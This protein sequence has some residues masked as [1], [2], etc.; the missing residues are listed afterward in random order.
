MSDSLLL[1]PMP[2]SLETGDRLTLRST[3]YTRDGD[4]TWADERGRPFGSDEE[5]RAAY[6][7]RQSLA[8]VGAPFFAPG[9]VPY[10]GALPGTVLR[11]GDW[12]LAEGVTYLWCEGDG[13]GLLLGAPGP[14]GPW[15]LAQHHQACREM[16]VADEVH[17]WSV[18][19]NG[20]WFVRRGRILRAYLP[21]DMPDCP[22]G[23]AGAIVPG[24][25]NHRH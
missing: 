22:P 8:E 12:V 4:G 14:L 10:S 9:P 24:Q 5:V 19:A 1:P 18:T 16:P 6:R 21:A 2:R 11:P 20:R 3:T 13:D 23:G 25:P 15:G 17:R 7:S